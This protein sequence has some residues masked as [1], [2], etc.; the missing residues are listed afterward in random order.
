MD[1]ENGSRATSLLCISSGG[2][3]NL[4]NAIDEREIHGKKKS[5]SG[6]FRAKI[7]LS[8]L[9][10]V[11]S[12]PHYNFKKSEW[13]ERTLSREPGEFLGAH[14]FVMGLSSDSA[15]L[16]MLRANSSGPKVVIFFLLLSPE[17]AAHRNHILIPDF[18]N[19][20]RFRIYFHPSHH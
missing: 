10:C 4:I 7:T 9:K 3:S 18:G 20:M 5:A 2:S 15:Y 8:K 17:V 16:V 1:D 12:Y 11:S 19:S 14:G 13:E 6:R